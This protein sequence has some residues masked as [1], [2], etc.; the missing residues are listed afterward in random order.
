MVTHIVS[1]YS[2][3]QCIFHRT[4]LQIYNINYN[5]AYYFLHILLGIVYAGRDLVE[6]SRLH[7]SPAMR[8]MQSAIQQHLCSRE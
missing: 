8:D 1:S 3:V 4:L 5:Y 2:I 6:I 7:C